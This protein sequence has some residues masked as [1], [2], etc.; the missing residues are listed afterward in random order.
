MTNEPD[1]G[2]VNDPQKSL[3]IPPALHQINR[4][5][6]TD[7]S[8]CRMAVAMDRDNPQLIASSCGTQLAADRGV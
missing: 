5:K 6:V 3:S 1:N 7:R 4:S 2:T 8:A